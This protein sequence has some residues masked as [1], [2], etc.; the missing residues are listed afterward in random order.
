M[1]L[2][3]LSRYYKLRLQLDEDKE[4]LRSLREKASGSSS[5][6][7]SG[8]PHTPGVSD[9]VGNFAAE[10]ADMEA[11]ICRKEMQAEEEKHRLLD[12]I[13]TISDSRTRTIFRLRFV[14]CLSWKE[15]AGMMGRY[16]SAN[17]VK[18]LCYDYL[19]SRKD[20]DSPD[21]DV[22]AHYRV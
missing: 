16:Y 4:V 19:N 18:H 7:L 3:E 5:P 17:R 9:K 8:M 21:Q 2:Q 22:S 6:S 10:I 15:V 1:T 13:N 12:K 20:V 11:E 14:R